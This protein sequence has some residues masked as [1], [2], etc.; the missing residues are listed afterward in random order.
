M[1][2]VLSLAGPVLLAV[3]R[4]E[5][6]LSE[7]WPTSEIVVGVVAHCLALFVA[8]LVTRRLASPLAASGAALLFLAAVVPVVVATDLIEKAMAGQATPTQLEAVTSL[9]LRTTVL[10]TLAVGSVVGWILSVAD[11][12]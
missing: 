2:L 8:V 11:E 4:S 5:L 9:M 6:H 12:I 3:L 1:L 10:A 7:N